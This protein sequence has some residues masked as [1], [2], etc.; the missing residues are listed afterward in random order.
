MILLSCVTVDFRLSFDKVTGACAGVG[1]SG[2]G[3]VWSL[4]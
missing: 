2:E 3:S 4:W 1:P